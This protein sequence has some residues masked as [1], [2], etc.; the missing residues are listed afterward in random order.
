MRGKFTY[1]MCGLVL[2]L[3]P[4]VLHAHG[5][6]VLSGEEQRCYAMAM[7][8]LD[9][10]INSRLGVPAEHVLRLATNNRLSLQEVATDTRG[11]SIPLLKTMLAAYLWERSPHSYGVKVFY[12]CASGQAPL[13]S[14]LNSI[15]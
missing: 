3:L 15:R 9:S 10:V 6:M 13:R 1:S 12:K 2:I 5:S 11:Y 4:Q 8:G 7:I 14:A